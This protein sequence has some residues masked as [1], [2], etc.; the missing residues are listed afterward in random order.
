MA[1]LMKQPV[2]KPAL[3]NGKHTQRG[4]LKKQLLKAYMHR[5]TA[6]ALLQNLLQ[7]MEKQV[8]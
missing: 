6:V 1:N 2:F 5:Q 8:I 7:Q 4:H 3:I